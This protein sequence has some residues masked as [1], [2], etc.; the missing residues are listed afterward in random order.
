M[1][2]KAP[3]V[4][5]MKSWLQLTKWVSTFSAGARSPV[6]LDRPHTDANSR[7]AEL[8]HHL[9]AQARGTHPAVAVMARF[10]LAWVTVAATVSSALLSTWVAWIFGFV[11][12][13]PNYGVHILLAFIIPFFVTPAFSY[14]TALSMRDMKRARARSRQLA[15]DAERERQHLHAAVNNMPIGLVMFD[16]NKQLIVGND[17]YRELYDLPEGSMTRGTYLRTMLE[18]RLRTGKFEGEREAYVDRILRLVE[19][20]ESTVRVVK[21]GDGRAVNIIHHPLETGGW[22][23]THEDVTE[24]ERLSAQLAHQTGLLKEREHQLHSQNALFEAALSNMSQGLCMFDQHN[25]LV[26]CNDQ[27]RT[28]YNVSAEETKPGITLCE[29]L[30]HRAANGSYPAGPLPEAY[31]ENLMAALGANS[32]WSKVTELHDGRF[33]SVVNCTMANGG[34]VATHE[35]VT[36]LRMREQELRAQNHRFDAAINNMPQGLC[37]FDTHQRLVICNDRY[38]EIYG[39]R[40]GKTKP[41]TPLSDILAER[42]ANGLYADD[43]HEN[44][45]RK[46]LTIAAVN[47]PATTVT[48]LQ[49]GRT[50]VVKHKPM[51]GGGWVA[52]H[53]DITEQRRIEARIEHMAHHDAL[54]DLPNRFLLRDGLESALLKATSEHP[55]AVLWLDFDR[56]K[57]VNDTL[58]HAVGDALLK[59]AGERLRGCIRDHDTIARLG[60]DEFAIVQTGTC[61]PEGAKALAQR[62]IDAIGAPYNVGG[63]QVVIGT[64]IGISICPID[65]TDPDRILKYADL[66]LYRAKAEGRNTFRFFE[67]GMDDQMHARRHLEMDLRNALVDGAF[68]LHYQPIV[69]LDR[70][71][72]VTF[73]ALLRWNHPSRGRISPAEFIPLAE[74]IGLIASIGEWVIRAACAD[75]A[76]WPKSIKVAVNLSPLQFNQDDLV[77]LVFNALAAAGLDPKRL[78]L[79]ITESVLLENT[80]KT[81]GTLNE[82]R[83]L[84]ICISMDDFGTGYSSLSNLRGFPFDKIKID[85]SFIQGLG[86]DDQCSTIIQAVTALGAGLGM[87]ITAEGV[88]TREQLDVLRDLGVNEVQGYYIS[89][90]APARDALRGITRIRN[91]TVIAA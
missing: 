85:Q 11:I 19:A 23:G 78:E 25:R 88:E 31:V 36:Q 47:E 89:R 37:M 66:A 46:L 80:E 76:L 20:K 7:K 18:E 52:T 12:D 75:A 81:L 67:P 91:K 82:L 68:E 40:P 26:L 42:V 28:M 70:N 3:C 65:T 10:G 57:D 49:N 56:F 8:S 62:V 2:S 14:F 22:I 74:E 16:A 1:L 41:G 51:S 63:H 69:N 54:T 38:A 17:R 21:L 55:V 77:Q 13:V 50:V 24:R 43:Q 39:L 34:W 53:E 73:E 90:P 44:Y 86:N 33:I 29:L 58:G 9:A 15:E 30:Q 59:D 27:Y 84:G 83:K 64:S 79:E 61:Q 45:A 48:E 71:E 35:D 6:A 5:I 72:V 87:I 4:C 60:G 32:T